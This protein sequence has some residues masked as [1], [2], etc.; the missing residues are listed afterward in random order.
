MAK[1]NKKVVEEPVQET[2]ESQEKKKGKVGKGI[3]LFFLM[4]LLISLLGSVIF[5]FVNDNFKEMANKT[6]RKAPGPIGTYFSKIPTKEE[7][8]LQ[9]HYLAQNYL[10]METKQAADKLLYVESKDK[11]VYHELI[12]KMRIISYRGTEKIL[13][14]I[15]KREP[16]SGLLNTLYEEIN[17]EEQENF[18]QSLNYLNSLETYQQI[19]KIKNDYLISYETVENLNR[20]LEKIEKQKLIQILYHIDE[21]AKH[22]IM[23]RMNPKLRDEMNKALAEKALKTE[24]LEAK[25]AFYEQMDAKLAAEDLTNEGKFTKE[26]LAYIYNGLS[27][28]KASDI[29]RHAEDRKWIEDLYRFIQIDAKNRGYASEKVINMDRTINFLNEYDKKIKNLA[30]IYKEVTPDELKTMVEKMLLSDEPIKTFRVDDE[31]VVEISDAKIILD[32]L[33]TFDGKALSLL[34]E[35]L[36]PRKAAELTRRLAI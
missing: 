11:A 9:L 33:K 30:D 36:D 18:E 24:D 26:E 8:S 32:M 29:L 19:E 20:V 21:D 10:N 4:L 28:L 1:K 23:S 3:G 14:E 31:Q 27:T 25:I 34:L 12:G 22:L 5:Y 35:K 6:L 15:Q 13:E 17:K 7:K 2:S 16:K